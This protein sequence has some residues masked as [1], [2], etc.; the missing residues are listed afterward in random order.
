MSWLG[1]V[2]HAL[3]GG[4]SE[5][6]V[7]SPSA[8]VPTERP[9]ILDELRALLISCS[10][11]P[12]APEHVDV[13]GDLFELGYVDSVSAASFVDRVERRFGI[14]ISDAELV[15]RLHSLAAIADR[16]APATLRT[17]SR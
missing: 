6:R 11:A 7:L 14:T 13:D 17:G 8:E 3:A 5:P 2:R 16:L 9:A 15:G 4:S 12:L 1:K 10:A